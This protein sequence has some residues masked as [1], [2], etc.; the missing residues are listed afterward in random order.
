MSVFYSNN[1]KKTRQEKTDNDDRPTECVMC[2]VNYTV[3]VRV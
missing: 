3:Y 1:S 2:G